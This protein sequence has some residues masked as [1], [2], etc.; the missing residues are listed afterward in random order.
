MKRTVISLV[1]GLVLTLAGM[2]WN[3]LSYRE[4][5]WLRLAY[6]MFGGEI[7]IQSGF[8]LRLVHIYSMRPEKG[9][10]ISLR[11]DPISFLVCLIVLSFLVYVILTVIV[12]IRRGAYTE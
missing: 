6:N 9:D 3:Y 10:S 4:D 5:K 2:L 7:T 12:K 1:S 11:F 8:G